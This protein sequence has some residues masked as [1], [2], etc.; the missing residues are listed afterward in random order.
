MKMV[1][2]IEPPIGSTFKRLDR[3]CLSCAVLFDSA[4][5]GERICRRCKATVAW[6]NG[7]APS[8]I[9]RGSYQSRSDRTG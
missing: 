2:V 1:T 4:W 7:A 9:G 6:R 5:A 8:T 3:H